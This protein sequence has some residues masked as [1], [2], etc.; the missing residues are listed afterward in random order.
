[1]DKVKEIKN[2]DGG[3]FW[4]A[5]PQ[6]T[7]IKPFSDLY[8]KKNSSK[9]AWCIVL[10][11]ENSDNSIFAHFPEKERMEELNHWHKDMNWEDKIVK[12]C[13]IKYPFIAMT[14]AAR[15]LKEEEEVIMKRSHFLRTAYDAAIKTNDTREISS[16]EKMLANSSGLYDN[17]EK[18]LEKFNIE[19][20]K[21][22]LRGGRE[23]SFGERGII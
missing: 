15:A 1:M 10:F 20:K 3:D 14:A 16:L 11:C 22:E 8:T 13:L 17:L 9:T 12:D 2:Y 7:L 19:R 18:A 6:F 4:E 5:N 23:E 21:A